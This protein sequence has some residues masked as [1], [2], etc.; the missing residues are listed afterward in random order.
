MHELNLFLHGSLTTQIGAR[1]SMCSTSFGGTAELK[2][3]CNCRTEVCESS[4]QS[5]WRLCMLRVHVGTVRE[6]PTPTYYKG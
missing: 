6:D 5:E 3:A 2:A 4:L 1:E